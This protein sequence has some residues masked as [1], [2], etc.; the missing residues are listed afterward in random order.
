MRRMTALCVIAGA[1]MTSMLVGCRVDSSKDGEHE[2]VK[3]ATPFGGMSVKTNEAVVQEGVG[4][5]VYPGATLAK[6]KHDQGGDEGAADVNL[7]FG[8]FKLRVKALSYT[9]P[10]APDKVLAFYRKDMARYGVVILCQGNHPVGTPA[11][12]QDGLSCAEEKNAKVHA[13]DNDSDQELK[14]GSRLHQHIVGIDPQGIGTKIGFVALDLPGHLG[15][16]NSDSQQ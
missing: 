14:A 11:V 1:A 4:L 16:E 13:G 3:I 6:K 12:T 10:D 2:N 7:S 8:N 15:L 9:T 5:T